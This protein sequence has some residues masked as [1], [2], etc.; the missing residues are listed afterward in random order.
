MR[1]LSSVTSRSHHFLYNISLL[2]FLLYSPSA[3]R[4][5]GNAESTTTVFVDR[6]AQCQASED[7]SSF[8]RECAHTY[9]LGVANAIRLFSTPPTKVGLAE[10]SATAFGERSTVQRMS[11]NKLRIVDH[12][13]CHCIGVRQWMCACGVIAVDGLFARRHSMLTVCQSRCDST[14][15]ANG[16]YTVRRRK[17]L[18]CSRICRRKQS[19]LPSADT[20]EY[21][22]RPSFLSGCTHRDLRQCRLSTATFN[23]QG[24]I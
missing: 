21:F 16:T 6:V 9:A 10:A 2:G 24:Q 19:L 12:R 1:T 5:F 17:W 3:V 18:R 23:T 7:S 22:D 20:G 13:R 14:D 8:V 11:A 4:A 15:A